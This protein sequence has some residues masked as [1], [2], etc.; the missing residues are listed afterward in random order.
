MDGAT[1]ANFL[2]IGNKY[3][4]FRASV[5]TDAEAQGNIYTIGTL[6]VI[7][8]PDELVQ[9]DRRGV[10]QTCKWCPAI[11]PVHAAIR[12]ARNALF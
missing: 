1:V 2:S 4:I 5:K 12:H 3:S 6:K 7:G 8:V 9:T 10:A 11:L